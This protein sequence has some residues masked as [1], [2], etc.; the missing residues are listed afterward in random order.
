MDILKLSDIVISDLNKLIQKDYILEQCI[1]KN[2]DSIKL[3]IGS[4]ALSSVTS[5]S[6]LNL[7]Q[8][9][10]HNAEKDWNEF[11]ITDYLN[12]RDS[13]TQIS[14]YGTTQEDILRLGQNSVK[15]SRLMY[16]YQDSLQTKHLGNYENSGLCAYSMNPYYYS[17]VLIS[18]LA[19]QQILNHAIKGDR[20]EIM[21]ILLG[22]VS[23][24]NFIVT[25]TF[26]LPVL[27]TETR[28]N[29]Q[30]ES[31]EYMVQYIDKIIEQDEIYGNEKV[32][33]W[34]HSHPGYDCWLSSIDMRT[35]D[36]NQSFQDPY[37][38][39][40]V[41]PLKSIQ[42]KKIFI[43]AF[44]TVKL[45]KNLSSQPDVEELSFYRLGISMFD[46]EL[47][48]CINEVK[49]TFKFDIDRYNSR[50][51]KI[52]RLAQTLLENM[53]HIKNMNS[54]RSNTVYVKKEDCPVTT[55]NINDKYVLQCQQY[56]DNRESISINS[57]K[58]PNYNDIINMITFD[59]SPYESMV[60]INSML[61]NRDVEFMHNETDIEMESVNSSIYFGTEN[62]LIDNE[63]SQ[64]T[65][66]SSITHQTLHQLQPQQDSKLQTPSVDKT[67]I[68]KDTI[69]NSNNDDD[70][71]NTDIIKNDHI[72]PT[73]IAIEREHEYLSY[74]ATKRLII[75]LKLQAYRDLRFYRDVFTL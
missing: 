20:L 49:L 63:Q 35:Q 62:M 51:D 65:S 67:N 59:A 32:V 75:R 64:K 46:S 9:C 29:A 30:S 40:V 73:S 31:Y 72:N 23:K 43:G 8:Q 13:V 70:H 11:P 57:E 61:N 38:A 1:K 27:G 58:S 50:R 54:L 18:R 47:N 5:L 44:R 39:I 71:N 10:E 28:V 22:F 56:Q 52:C 69:N 45:D 37:L 66:F 7:L 17:N 48:K 24:N 33:G 53:K 21:G 68:I 26:E 36:L 6:S 34:Y 41:D 55:Q 60:S 42:D 16:T 14:M 25:R 15:D 3:H 4:K 2:H 74:V 12:S 19:S